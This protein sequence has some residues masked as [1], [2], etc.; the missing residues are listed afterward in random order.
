[1]EYTL[2]LTV[3]KIENETNTIKKFTLTSDQILPAFGAGAHVTL[4]LPMGNRQYSL[5][6]NPFEMKNEYVIAVKKISDHNSGSGYL[7]ECINQGDSITASPP[8]NFFPLR[9]EAK[10]HVFFAAG[11]GI[12]PFISMME[13]LK[14][15][16]HSFELHYAAPGERECGFYHYIKTRFSNES[17]F[18]FMKREEKIE[19]LKKALQN[20]TMG[21]HIYLCGPQTFMD[22]LGDY[23]HNLRYPEKFIHEERFQP[24]AQIED[25]QPFIVTLVKSEETFRVNSG[26]TLLDALHE[27]GF[28]IPYTCRMGVCGTCEAGVEEGEV[29][30]CDSFLTDEEKKEKMLTCVSRG[31]EHI[32]LRL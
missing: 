31:I 10:H 21:T 20:R 25:P 30:H 18:Y 24:A 26:Q 4:H 27:K 32:K 1:M 8:D 17:T 7:H 14:A 6:N 23:S 11:I 28:D 22:M 5:V 15:I 2:R 9:T 19:T 29:L 13:Y 12:T 16:G 3:K